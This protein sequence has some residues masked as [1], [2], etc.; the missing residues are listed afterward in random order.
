MI[1]GDTPYGW[2]AAQFPAE[3]A[4]TQIAGNFPANVSVYSQRI[5]QIVNLRRGEVF[6]LFEGEP[7]LARSKK[8]E[9][10]NAVFKTL[11][12][13]ESA[14]GCHYLNKTISLLNWEQK[15][16]LVVDSSSGCHLSAFER[17]KPGEQADHFYE[18][19]AQQLLAVY[20][21]EMDV[22]S[23]RKFQAFIGQASYKYR[24]CAL[25]KHL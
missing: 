1:G 25:S 15:V 9:K 6:A 18:E 3:V 4:F 19:R 16:K 24:W 8:I 22:S 12:V 13:T 11:S 21:Y 5:D 10:A 7:N 20:G 14:T 17:D 23:C 2:L